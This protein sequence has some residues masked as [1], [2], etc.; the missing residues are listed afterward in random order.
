MV[1]PLLFLHHLAITINSIN[2]TATIPTIPPI[3]ST[4]SFFLPGWGGLVGDA[5]ELVGDAGFVEGFVEGFA[6]GGGS[7]LSQI[8]SNTK[9]DTVTLPP[10]LTIFKISLQICSP[11]HPNKS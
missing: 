4:L 10:V 3:N 1:Y 11:L 5:G 2:T 8:C 7:T 9:P 6:L